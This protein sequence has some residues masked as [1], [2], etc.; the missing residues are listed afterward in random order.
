M[1]SSLIKPISTFARRVGRALRDSQK[2]LLADYL[3]TVAVNQSTNFQLLKEKHKEVVLEIG[4][5]NG[6]YLLDC[7]KKNPENLY[8]GAEPFLNGVSSMLSKARAEN[9]NNIMVYTDDAR[10][11]LKAM[12]NDYLD[13]INLICPDPWPKKKQNKRRIVNH[14]FLELAAQKI[15]PRGCLFIVTDHD[16]YATWI[17]VHLASCGAL[18]VVQ[19]DTTPPDDWLYTKYQRRGINLGSDIKF[20]L[21]KRG[22]MKGGVLNATTGNLVSQV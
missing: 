7:A 17:D 19:N 3:P 18:R 5:G 15:S 12:P 2:A 1:N 13:R 4:F 20:F 11:L 21:A 22:L 10:E 14:E 8:I 16:D 6:E 9:L